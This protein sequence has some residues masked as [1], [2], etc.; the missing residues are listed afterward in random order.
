MRWLD[1]IT[2]ALDMNLDKLWEILR[3]KKACHAVVHGVVKSQT[4]LGNWTETSD[5]GEEK[6]KNPNLKRSS[7]SVTIY[8]KLDSIQP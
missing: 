6:E 5:S 3:D 7:K 2:D 4:W 1:G 8:R